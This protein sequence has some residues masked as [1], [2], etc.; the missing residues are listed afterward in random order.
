MVGMSKFFRGMWCGFNYE[1]IIRDIGIFLYNI[2]SDGWMVNFII[3]LI[4]IYDLFNLIFV[5]FRT[6]AK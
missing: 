2:G 3:Y 1:S 5:F 6:K 4:L